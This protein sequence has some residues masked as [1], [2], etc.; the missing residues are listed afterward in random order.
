MTSLVVVVEE[1]VVVLVTLKWLLYDDFG[2][3]SFRV[4]HG[5]VSSWYCC[6]RGGGI[7]ASGR[8]G[9]GEGVVTL[10]IL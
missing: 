3:W 6:C 5:N 8:S 4:L 10:F 9:D 2:V 7:V 1:F